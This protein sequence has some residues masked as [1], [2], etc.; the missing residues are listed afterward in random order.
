MNH[1]ENKKKVLTLTR[2]EGWIR[3]KQQQVKEWSSIFGRK[4]IDGISDKRG[5]GTSVIFDKW[6]KGTNDI[7]VKWKKGTKC[8]SVLLIAL[9]PESRWP[10]GTQQTSKS[11]SREARQHFENSLRG[12]TAL[13]KAGR[14]NLFLINFHFSYFRFFSSF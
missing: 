5:K 9:F 7:S 13:R 3:V 2:K 12:W 1:T 8:I 4:W 14:C 6:E 11:T 10:P